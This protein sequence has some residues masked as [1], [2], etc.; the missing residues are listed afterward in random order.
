MQRKHLLIF[1]VL[2]A[3]IGILLLPTAGLAAGAPKL[4]WSA[5]ATAGTFTPATPT[6]PANFSFYTVDAGTGPSQTFTLT[7]SGGTAT[8]ALKV[9]LSGTNA[10]EFS[11]SNNTCSARSLG[12]KKHCSVTVTYTETAQGANDTG[13]LTA[14]SK[15]SAAIASVTLRGATTVAPGTISWKPSSLDFPPTPIG[16]T[17]LMT[18]VLTNDSDTSVN[19]YE[20]TIASGSQPLP[21]IFADQSPTTA[22]VYDVQ[23]LAPGQTCTITI[24]FDP[25]VAGYVTGTLIAILTTGSSATASLTGT[26]S[27]S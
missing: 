12:P 6:T 10:S 15:K 16:Q 26:G 7:N 27:A 13:A 19:L 2:A 22:C 20:L 8:S 5:T 18:D 1:G 25:A 14:V 11:I 4:V 3:A 9:S 21:W 24:G 23:V 17:V